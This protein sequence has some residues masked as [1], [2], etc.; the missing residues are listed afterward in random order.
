MKTGLGHAKLT[1]A[2]QYFLDTCPAVVSWGHCEDKTDGHDP[3]ECCQFE[4]DETVEVSLVPDG[5][6]FA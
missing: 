4:Y 2:T 1:P 6:D 3:D 5:V